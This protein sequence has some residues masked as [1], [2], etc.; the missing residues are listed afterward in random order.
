MLLTLIQHSLR[1]SL[2]MKFFDQAPADRLD[3][4]ARLGVSKTRTAHLLKVDSLRLLQNVT[5]VS[6]LISALHLRLV[7]F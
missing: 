3:L 5:S 2:A 1:C 7:D 6:S 4:D